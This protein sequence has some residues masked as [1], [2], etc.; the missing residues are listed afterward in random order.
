MPPSRREPEDDGE[1][2]D[3]DNPRRSSA[4]VEPD[5]RSLPGVRR[6]VD[7][8]SDLADVSDRTRYMLKVAV[9]E[10]V[11]NAIEHGSAFGAPVHLT[12]RVNPDAVTFTVGDPGAPFPLEPDPRPGLQPRGRGLLLMRRCVDEGS[13]EPLEQGKRGRLKKRLS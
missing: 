3:D 6:L 1:D 10:A 2:G 4:D 12:A 8:V 13:L 7:A 5:L 9:H 11:T